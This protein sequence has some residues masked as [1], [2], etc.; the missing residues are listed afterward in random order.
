MTCKVWLGPFWFVIFV[1]KFRPYGSITHCFR[2]FCSFF[3]NGLYNMSHI[4]RK[5]VF[6]VSD[7]LRLKPACSATEYSYSLE[8]LKSDRRGIILSRQRTTKVLIRLRKCAGWSAPL[9]FAHAKNR[10]SH[11]MA[12]MKHSVTISMFVFYYGNLLSLGKNWVCQFLELTLVLWP[13]YCCCRKY[14]ETYQ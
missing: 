8:I 11:D 14:S 13:D 2:G 5:P 10:F 9:L 3:C 6:R 12:H 7:Q 4:T 1:V